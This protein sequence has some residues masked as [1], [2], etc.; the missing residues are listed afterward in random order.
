MTSTSRARE[1]LAAVGRTGKTVG[2]G[3]KDRTNRLQPHLR[4]A[5]ARVADAAT[6]AV[7]ATRRGA[8][9]LAAGARPGAKELAHRVRTAVADL[10]PAAKHEL[11]ESV[12]RLRGVR[13]LD[14]AVKALTKEIE[15]LLHVFTPVFV[16][17]P[18]GLEPSS[19]RAVVGVTAAA[20]AILGEA[21]AVAVLTPGGQGGAAAV[22]LVLVADFTALVLE[23]YAGASVRTR[24]LQA[25]GLTPDPLVIAEEL[26][27]AMIGVSN[28]EQITDQVMKQLA[29]RVARRWA[30][31]LAPAAGAA[32]VGWNAQK[33][34]AVMAALPIEGSAAPAD[35]PSSSS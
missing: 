26:A 18:L 9:T 14:D 10:P 32:Y 7:S 24:T 6:T 22:P 20:S 1:V 3:A 5:A 27:G 16:A 23:A 8:T 11:R 25:A 4:D 17:H 29:K 34:V 28:R 31:G 12:Q 21:D 19:A 13:S 35:Q 2:A 30:I 33:T 15:R